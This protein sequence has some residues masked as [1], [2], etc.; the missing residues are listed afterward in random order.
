M[1]AAVVAIVAVVLVGGGFVAGRSTDSVETVTV[2]V[3][4]EVVEVLVPADEFTAEQLME[5]ACDRATRAIG[6]AVERAQDEL[7]VATG[8][9]DAPLVG[10]APSIWQYADPVELDRAAITALAAATREPSLW[11]DARPLVE[12]A[13]RPSTMPNS[14]FRV[15]DTTP[16]ARTEALHTVEM[17][18][19]A[20]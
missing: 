17:S 15:I 8:G 9:G 16:E 6:E 1:R 7:D 13:A 2:P 3:E 10:E 4:P 14:I 18:C 19:R 11:P 5:H 12:L 20:R